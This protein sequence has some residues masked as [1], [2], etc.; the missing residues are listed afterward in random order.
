MA[1]VQDGPAVAAA[2]TITGACV[3]ALRAPVTSVVLYGSLTLDDFVPARSDIDLLVVV[4]EP[5]TDDEIGALTAV[6]ASAD[7]A[8][9]AGIDLHVVTS[10]VA[11]APPRN[12]PLE[13]HVGRYPDSDLEVEPRL[14]GAPDL[15]AELSMARADGRGLLGSSPREVIGVIDPDWIR[16]RGEHW[17]TTWLTLVDDAE[18]AGFMV[19]T[20]CRMWRFHREGVHSSKTAAARWALARDRSLVAVRQALGQRTGDRATVVDE[21]GVRAVLETVRDEIRAGGTQHPDR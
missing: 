8:P 9:A 13:L 7:A 21:D 16:A 19:L 5:P 12:P 2:R 20:A 1:I 3:A 15:L 17:L 4:D 14:A 11:A 6:V 10:D 18:H